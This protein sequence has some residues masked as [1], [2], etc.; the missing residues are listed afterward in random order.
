MKAQLK[1]WKNQE[2]AMGTF[3]QLDIVSSLPIEEVSSAMDCAFAAFRTV[4]Q[5]CSRFDA[6]SELRQLA[7]QIGKPLVVSDVLFE[8][9]RFALSVAEASGGA[10]DPTVGGVMEQYGFTRHYLTGESMPSSQKNEASVS[11]RDVS[12]DETE[13]TVVIHKPL[14]LDLGAVAKGFA[15]DLASKILEP[16]QGF[17]IN[18]GGDIYAGGTN[19]WESPWKI[20]IRS[21]FDKRSSLCSV[22]LSQ[23]A[24]CT[25][26]SYE[27]I[28]PADGKSHHL[29]SPHTRQSANE[30][31]SCTVLAP[32]AM[33]ADAFST[34][35]FVLGPEKGSRLLER[36]ELEGL[37]FDESKHTHMTHGMEA[38]I[39]GI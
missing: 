37:W 5:A 3:I 27:R 18:A 38:F 31:V 11:F 24:V 25:S 23:A 21:P 6:Q 35:A 2:I 1:R 19:E 15:V 4:E 26:G 12:I 14:L 33:M 17:V 28:S 13:R 22:K 30:T 9:L 7:F 34:A 20:G 29:I 10:F 36:F 39:D 32:F 16:F 8:T